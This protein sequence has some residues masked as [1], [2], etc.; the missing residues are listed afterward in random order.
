MLAFLN[1]VVADFYLKIMNPT[2]NFPPGYIQSIPF[3]EKIISKDV[4]DVSIECVALSKTDW[5]SYE[6]SWDFKRNP[7]V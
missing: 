3:S 6:S 2:I 7:L 4:E 5:N 1:S